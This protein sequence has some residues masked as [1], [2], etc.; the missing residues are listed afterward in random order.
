MVKFNVYFILSSLLNSSEAISGSSTGFQN[1]ISIFI[2]HPDM[3]C[4]WMQAVFQIFSTL[5]ANTIIIAFK[6]S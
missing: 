3:V 1:R 2:S 4:Y 6:T 5:N